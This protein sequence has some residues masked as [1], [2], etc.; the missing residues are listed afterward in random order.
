[1]ELLT[2]KFKSGDIIL[3]DVAAAEGDAEPK[4]LVF[5]PVIED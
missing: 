3:V 5:S 1:M 4:K 2:G